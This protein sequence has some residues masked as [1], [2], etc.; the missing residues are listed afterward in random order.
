MMKLIRIIILCLLTLAPCYGQS[1][2]NLYDV[3]IKKNI[4]I[5]YRPEPIPYGFSV[6]PLEW[7][8]TLGRLSELDFEYLIPG[9]GEVQQGK[10]YLQK[11]MRLLQSVQEQ[12]RASVAAGLDLESTRKK[13]DL[14]KFIGE[15]TR[16]DAVLLYRFQGWFIDPNVGETF[17]E[18]KQKSELTGRAHNAGTDK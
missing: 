14:S 15:F 17:K 6:R 7:L 2:S 10:A 8:V 1:K 9:H 4:Y 12:V 5:A 16:H 3:K 13:V 11:V 18:I